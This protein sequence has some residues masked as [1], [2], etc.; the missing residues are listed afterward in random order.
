MTAMKKGLGRGL[1]SLFSEQ[2]EE[3]DESS[4]QEIDIN[5]IEPNQDQPRIDFD[6]DSLAELADSIKQYGVLQ[7]IIVAKEKDYYK[8]IAGER[9]FRASRLAKLE[10]I[11][12]IVKT[13]TEIEQLQVALVENLQRK[14]LNPIEE[15]LCYRR[16]IENFEKTQEELS[17]SVGKSRPAITNSLRLLNLDKRVQSF[18]VDGRLSMGHGR[19]LLSIESA[20][21]QFELAE[22]I[23]EEEMSVREVEEA[24]RKLTEPKKA[25]VKQKSKPSKKNEYKFAE[26]NMMAALG[27]KV[28]VVQGKRKGKIEIEFYSPE[29]L[30]RIMTIIRK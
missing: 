6:A 11:P 23:I 19:T 10:K 3:Y 22:R 1:N 18:L 5:I 17:A 16:L 26:D 12:C 27:T 14:D 28:T 25:A 8:I 20:E 9:R 29:D 4:L 21:L 2:I 13:F 7:P 15:A 30:D 24:V